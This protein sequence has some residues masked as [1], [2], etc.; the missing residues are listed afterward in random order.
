MKA[1]AEDYNSPKRAEIEGS[2]QYKSLNNM[3][4]KNS[5]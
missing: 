4:G 5:K 3:Y 1:S 2:K